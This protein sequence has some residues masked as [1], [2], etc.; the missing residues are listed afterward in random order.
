MR[1]PLLDTHKKSF[2]LILGLCLLLLFFLPGSANAQ[3]KKIDSLR[4]LLHSTKEPAVQLSHLLSLGKE[5]NSLPADSIYWYGEQAKK[6]AIQLKDSKSEAWADYGLY[7]HLL[8]TGQADS[9]LKTIDSYLSKTEVIEDRDLYYKMALLKANALNRQN[10]LNEA[11]ELQLQL[12]T[13]AQKENATESVLFLMNYIGASYLN[14]NKLEE[15]KIWWMK[16]L[17]II[18]SSTPE[19]YSY[20][21]ATIL[22]NLGL[23]YYNMLAGPVSLSYKDSCRFIL[24]KSIGIAKKY[25][26]LG[27][28]ASG[29]VL[30]GNFF[31]RTGQMKEAEQLL[32]EGISIRKKVGDPFYILQD[33]INLGGYY[34]TIGQYEKSR[35]IINEGIS[36]ASKNSIKADRLAMLGL[37]AYSYKAEHKYEAYGT[38]LEQFIQAADSVNRINSSLQLAEIQTKYNVQ[39]KEL[40]IA[41]QQF[42]LL[43]RKYLLYGSSILVLI[44]IIAG[45]IGFTNYRAKQKLL[46]EIAVDKEKKEKEIAVRTAQEKERIRIAA[47]L[48]DNIGVQ[49]SAILYGT[50]LLQT[51]TEKNSEIVDTLHDTAKEMLV[52]LRETLWAMNNSD[53]QA[54]ECWIRII[55][56]CKQM[57]KHYSHIQISAS[58]S[59]PPEYPLDSISA[60]H[61]MMI[62]KEAVNNGARHATANMISVSSA[63]NNNQWQLV[64]TDNGKGFD[65]KGQQPSKDSNGITNM[66][67]RAKAIGAEFELKS[68]QDKGT[69]IQL[70]IPIS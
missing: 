3:N 34:Y 2:P 47:D 10:K 18:N 4:L 41:A 66:T 8:V 30:K 53:I 67:E 48:H 16:A 29:L 44:G 43:K 36:L 14:L 65:W 63:V 5:K 15:S 9:L 33:L 70:T 31:S 25:E 42:S 59:T 38:A 11:I 46:L 69:S 32:N 49:A 58:G 19:I 51:G 57:E 39:Q 55:N 23:Y 64:I 6:I 17:D 37:I 35:A 54:T 21:E 7:S 1:E 68:Q 28:Q 22:G 13:S 26:L 40:Q 50:E 27:V 61:L 56:F 45:Y 20:I 24:D 60:L 52:N 62:V 12:L